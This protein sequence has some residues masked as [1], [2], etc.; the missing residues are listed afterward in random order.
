MNDCIIDVRTLEPYDRHPTIFQTFAILGTGDALQ[1]VN[2][3]D[4]QPLL[5]LFEQEL[6]GVFS[7]HYLE[8]GPVW[9][10]RIGKTAQSDKLVS[11][12]IGCGCM[13]H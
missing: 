9:R 8:R 5:R 10:V 3:H 13:A 6:A 1:I 12:R 2:D 11:G 4:P 7:W